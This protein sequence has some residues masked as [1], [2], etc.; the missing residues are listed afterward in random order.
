MVKKEVIKFP[1]QALKK[2]DMTIMD[3][4]RLNT[5]QKKTKI[6]KKEEDAQVAQTA[7]QAQNSKK[8]DIN[9]QNNKRNKEPTLTYL[10]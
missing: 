4:K 5:R 10:R 3:R 1:A 6:R 9:G 2:T 8:Q 7:I